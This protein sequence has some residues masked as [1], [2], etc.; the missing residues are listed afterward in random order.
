VKTTVG[1]HPYH[2]KEEGP[3][4]PENLSKL[5]HLLDG[6]NSNAI[7]SCI[8][9]TGLDYSD[10]FPERE[11]QIPW[12]GAQLDLAF[13]RNL[14]VFLHERLAFEDTLQCIDEAA[15]RHAG[16]TIPKIIVHCYTGYLRRVRGVHEEGLHVY[17]YIGVHPQ[18]RRGER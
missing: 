6:P 5:R 7:I 17:E 18:A 16:K 1:V 13:E 8:G 4:G 2:A 3:P 10:G 14:P 15:K 11:H 12:F 9:E